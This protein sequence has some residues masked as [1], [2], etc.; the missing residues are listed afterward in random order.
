MAVVH[1]D[2]Q[3]ALLGGGAQQ[4]LGRTGQQTL[5]QLRWQGRGELVDCLS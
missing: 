4:G 2:H 5:A 3:S 1:G